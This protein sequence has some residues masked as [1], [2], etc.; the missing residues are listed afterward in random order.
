MLV[1]IGGYSPL[2]VGTKKPQREVAASLTVKYVLSFTII[3]SLVF[4][5][6]LPFRYAVKAL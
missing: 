1:S 5:N 4:G 3:F 2:N 6:W